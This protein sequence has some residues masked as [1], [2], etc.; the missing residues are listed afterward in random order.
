[1]NISLCEKSFEQETSKQ[2]VIYKV[3]LGRISQVWVWESS[4][5]NEV[6]KTILSYISFFYKKISQAEEA[7]NTYKRK[8]K[9]KRQRSNAL[10]KHLRRKKL[11]ICLFAFLCLLCFLYFCAFYAFC[12]FCFCKIFSKK[13]FETALVTW[14][15]LLLNYFF[16]NHNLLQLSQS[17]LSQSLLL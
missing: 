4:N 15:A 10:K 9:P 8:K 7:Q 2:C 16:F 3:N 14:F 5:V 1:M 17:S 12:A 6:I 11:L 13:T